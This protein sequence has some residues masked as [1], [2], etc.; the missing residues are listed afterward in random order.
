[1]TT[2]PSSSKLLF[3]NLA[4]ANGVL[5][6]IVT[7]II[8]KRILNAR[9]DFLIMD[10]TWC[11]SHSICPK[12]FWCLWMF[13]LF[14]IFCCFVSKNRKKNELHHNF[15]LTQK[16]NTKCIN[17]TFRL[18][19][20]VVL[21]NKIKLIAFDIIRLNIWRIAFVDTA[22]LAKDGRWAR[23]WLVS[24]WY[25]YFQHFYNNFILL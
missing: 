9:T 1:M 18:I 17:A 12:G 11:E 19:H 13:F 3:K 8:K 5:F 20:P 22:F 25:Q 14:I 24:F 16:R 23:F 7:N 6:F 2:E 10:W 15:R 4:F 21:G